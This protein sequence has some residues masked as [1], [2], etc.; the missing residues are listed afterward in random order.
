MTRTFFIVTD[1]R[2]EPELFRDSEEAFE[3][4]KYVLMSYGERYDFSDEEVCEAIDEMSKMYNDGDFVDF[5]EGYL[6]ECLVCCYPR[7]VR[8]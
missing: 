1:E 2:T 6:G 4:M 3:Y 8:L 7:E 5:F